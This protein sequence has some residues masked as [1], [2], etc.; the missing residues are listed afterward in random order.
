[1]ASADHLQ[2][3][4]YGV[5][6]SVISAMRRQMQEGEHWT[7][8]AIGRVSYTAAGEA[9]LAHALGLK[10]KEGGAAPVGGA[11]D[12]G[13]LLMI[14]RVYPNRIWVRVATPD[15]AAADVRVRDNRRLRE[16]MKIACQQ[17]GAAWHCV[18]AGQA[19]S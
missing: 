19:V 5:A 4:R 11:T 18:H 9:A 16:R 7:A 6:V 3:S 13:Q 15:G 10:K 1:M 17:Q 2:A 8:D 14:V 12:C